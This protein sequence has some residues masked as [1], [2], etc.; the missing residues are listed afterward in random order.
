MTAKKSF[1]ERVQPILDQ[2]FDHRYKGL[3]H[4]DLQARLEA[5]AVAHETGRGSATVPVLNRQAFNEECA[6]IAR[7]MVYAR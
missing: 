3:T 6:A 7:A 4:A 2:A 1:R 5:L